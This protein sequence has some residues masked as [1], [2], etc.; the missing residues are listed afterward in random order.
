MV[1]FR[2]KLSRRGLVVPYEAPQGRPGEGLAAAAAELD[3]TVVED[4]ELLDRLTAVCRGAGGDR[5]AASTKAF[6]TCRARS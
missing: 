5:R 4:T 3:G 1:D 6:S 2:R